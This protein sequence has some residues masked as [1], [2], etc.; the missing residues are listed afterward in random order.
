MADLNEIVQFRLK[1]S[2]EAFEESLLLFKAE[3]YSSTISRLYYSAFY[4]VSALLLKD[5]IYSKSHSGL[6]SLFN[7]HLIKTNKLGSEEAEIYNTLFDS[8]QI[9]DYKDL[10]GFSREEVEPL[11]ERTKNLITELKKLI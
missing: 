3:H 2:D 8:R 5:R 9:A 10:S 6:K 7:E 1:K 11:I 4:A